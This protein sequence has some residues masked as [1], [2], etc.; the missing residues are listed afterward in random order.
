LE[1]SDVATFLPYYDG[2]RARTERVIAVV[3]ADRLEWRHKPPAFSCGDQIRHIAATERY[4]FAENV[5]GRPSRYPGHGSE[6]A[7]GYDDVLDYL[8]RCHEESVAIIAQLSPDELKLSCTTP[9]GTSIVRWKWLRA[10]VEHEVHHRAQIYH[11]LNLM[12]VPTPPIY[13]LT[14]EQVKANSI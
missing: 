10:M 13:G 4:M 14:S 3:P 12:D 9:A 2:I 7:D 11:T 6:L 1:I 8:R 5:A